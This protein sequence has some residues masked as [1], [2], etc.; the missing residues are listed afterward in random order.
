MFKRS[1]LWKKWHIFINIIPFL[2]GITLAKLLIHTYGFE[3]LSLNALFTS[4]VAANTFLIGFLIMGVISDYKESEKIPG[5]LASSLETLY[6]EAQI[7][8]INKKAKEAEDFIAYHSSFMDSLN[9]WFYK[10]ERTNA[11]LEK[12]S[13]MN[14]FFAKFEPLAQANFISRMKQEQSNI[15]RAIIRIHT[16]RETSFVQSAYAIVEALAFFLIIGL[17]LLKLEPFFEAVFFVNVVSFLVLYMILL[18]RDLDNPFDYAEF[19]ECGNDVSLKPLHDMKER[20]HGKYHG[21]ANS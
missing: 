15:R 9:N 12:V 3:A 14:L 19:G 7:I 1:Q 8:V 11:L 17:L 13:M 16:I 21:W 18:I 20:V 6:D 10:K 2:I 4:I 5:E